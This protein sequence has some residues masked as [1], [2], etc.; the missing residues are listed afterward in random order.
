MLLRFLICS[1]VQFLLQAHKLLS[2]D[3]VQKFW[4]AVCGVHGE[5]NHLL[6]LCSCFANGAEKVEIYVCCV[7]QLQL[8]A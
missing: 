1:I 6:T 8:G 2:S 4:N 7:F 3:E 5:Q